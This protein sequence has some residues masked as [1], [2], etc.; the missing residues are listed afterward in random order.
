MNVCITFKDYTSDEK[1]V[2][3]NPYMN[4]KHKYRVT[5]F[6]TKGIAII[7]SRDSNQERR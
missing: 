5:Y 6:L 4:F 7:P 2:A 3:R 1:Q